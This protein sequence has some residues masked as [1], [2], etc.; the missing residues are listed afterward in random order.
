[1]SK[2]NKRANIIKIIVLNIKSNKILKLQFTDKQ[3]M[4]F[5][6]TDFQPIYNK[7]PIA[8]A[9]IGKAKGDLCQIELT[10]ELYEVLDVL[11]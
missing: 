10:G 11:N 5:V 2:N 3:Q 4:S 8:N 9:L 6:H 7:A 1:M